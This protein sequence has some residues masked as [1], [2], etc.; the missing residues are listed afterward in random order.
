MNLQIGQ[1]TYNFKSGDILK[2]NKNKKS[3]SQSRPTFKKG[4][5]KENLEI[6]TIP[7]SVVNSIRNILKETS[8]H[9]LTFEVI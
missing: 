2:L 5:K 6:G 9:P 8:P 3:Y 1:T 7:F 4:E